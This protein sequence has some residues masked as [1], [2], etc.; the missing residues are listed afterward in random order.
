ML[1][2][3]SALRPPPHRS[4]GTRR[5]QSS[6]NT[7]RVA[8]DERDAAAPSLILF[9]LAGAGPGPDALLDLGAHLRKRE[10]LGKRPS[11]H[12]VVRVISL[13]LGRIF[14]N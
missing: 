3:F 9:L 6:G 12:H 10:R 13:L 2:W 4:P 7:L 1:L 8:D 5:V 11:T 14:A